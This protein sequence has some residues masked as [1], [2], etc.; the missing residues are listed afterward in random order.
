[1]NG[2]KKWHMVPIY[3]ILIGWGHG[4]A[5][6]VANH[7]WPYVIHFWLPGRQFFLL[8]T[9]LLCS[10]RIYRPNFSLCSPR[11]VFSKKCPFITLAVQLARGVKREGQGVKK[12]NGGAKIK[13]SIKII[14]ERSF[15]RSSTLY[16]PKTW[17]KGI[18]FAGSYVEFPW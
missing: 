3:R 17:Q 9:R 7:I 5:T 2:E 10:K 12:C 11:T 14:S 6:H 4:T 16:H 15:S 1:V 13:S 18:R 8:P